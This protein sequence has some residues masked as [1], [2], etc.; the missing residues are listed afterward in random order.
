[1]EL[2]CKVSFYVSLLGMLLSAVLSNASVREFFANTWVR[3]T[4]SSE[5]YTPQRVLQLTRRLVTVFYEHSPGQVSKTK[6]LIVSFVCAMLWT[7]FATQ[8]LP[9][10]T[11]PIIQRAG[12]TFF[13]IVV[14]LGLIPGLFL[15]ELFLGIGIVKSFKGFEQ[16][17]LSNSLIRVFIVSVFCSAVSTALFVFLVRNDDWIG[18]HTNG[19]GVSTA[20]LLIVYALALPGA[21]PRMV[22]VG[23]LARFPISNFPLILPAALSYGGTILLFLL[24]AAVLSCKPSL[25]C[26]C[27]LSEKLSAP[28]YRLIFKASFFLFTISTG[29]MQAFGIQL[30][31]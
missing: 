12:T 22:V 16:R 2:A 27:Y 25:R 9:K 18:A 26:F 8:T 5:A 30:P 6:I 21:L 13:F 10:I 20:W 23:D 28:T 7:A 1:M 29:F 14:T 17:T 19:R 24:A 15:F 11:S 4:A 3:A 31:R